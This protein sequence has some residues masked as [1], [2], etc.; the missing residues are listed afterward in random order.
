MK[1][2]NCCKC[3]KPIPKPRLKALPNTRECIV[4]SSEERNMVR[5]VITGKTTY[6]EVEVIKNKKTKE[7][8]NSL[9]GKGRRGFG[10]MLHRSTGSDTSPSKVK[11]GSSTGRILRMPTM[12]DF[13]RVGKQIMFYYE[14]EMPDKADRILHDALNNQHIT[15]NQYRQ[16]KE[17]IKHI[18]NGKSID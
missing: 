13:D 8:L 16:L 17:I 14:L 9:I 3:Y 5:A 18:D 7:Y 11:L 2:M 1:I 15:G 4:C 10:S 12:E 6:S